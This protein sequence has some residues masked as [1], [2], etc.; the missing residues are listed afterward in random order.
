[1]C[2]RE[3]KERVRKR[4]RE[5]ERKKESKRNRQ[6]LGEWLW[7]SWQ[8]IRFGHQRSAV[9]ILTLAIK[10]SNIIECQ[11]QSRRDKNKEKE[12]GNVPLKKLEKYRESKRKRKR[13]RERK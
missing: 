5:R 10:S 12:A 3:K 13:E 11:L 8:S 9:L 1:M 7:H 6:G 2:E 4:M